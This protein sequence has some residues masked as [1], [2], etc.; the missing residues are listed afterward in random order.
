MLGDSDLTSF[1]TPICCRLP[2]WAISQESP[3]LSWVSHSCTYCPR[4][5][6]GG[7]AR[8][9]AEDKVVPPRLPFSLHKGRTWAW[10]G[11]AALP[12][13]TPQQPGAQWNQEQQWPV[14]CF[15]TRIWWSHRPLSSA[16]SLLDLKW[17]QAPRAMVWVDLSSCL[18]IWIISQVERTRGVRG[19]WSAHRHSH[20]NGRAWS[21]RIPQRLPLPLSTQTLSSLVIYPLGKIPAPDLA[22]LSH[23]SVAPVI[24]MSR[25]STR[26]PLWSFSITFL[27]GSTYPSGNSSHIHVHSG[28][29]SC[30]KPQL[31]NLSRAWASKAEK[32]DN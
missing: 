26:L 7:W 13:S 1:P 16:R 22:S 8:T 11:P 23:S 14:C 17:L 19:P 4:E 21:N 10:D 5:R 30:L 9:S 6:W 31:D 12:L 24:S 25:V 28:S 20:L 3:A 18:R 29:S 32:M 2:K 27:P 15:R